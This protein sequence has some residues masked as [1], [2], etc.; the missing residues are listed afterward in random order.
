MFL[1][2]LCQDFYPA[3]GLCETNPDEI[4]TDVFREDANSSPGPF[5]HVQFFGEQ[6]FCCPV[7]ELKPLGLA[8]KGRH[9]FTRAQ[10]SG[11]PSGIVARI[12]LCQRMMR[13][14]HRG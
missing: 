2:I 14:S 9:I 5:L 12:V 3:I 10:G 1:R 6:R 8:A 7:E 4:R 13:S 11:D